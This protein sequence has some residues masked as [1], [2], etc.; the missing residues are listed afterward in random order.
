M[1]QGRSHLPGPT[2]PV[3]PAVPGGAVVP[4]SC[5]MLAPFLP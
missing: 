2:A 1:G 4:G 5:G 3:G